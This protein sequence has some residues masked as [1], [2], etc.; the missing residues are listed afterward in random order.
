MS[1]CCEQREQFVLA[2]DRWVRITGFYADRW[3]LGPN[4]Y[5]NPAGTAWR[6]GWQG[7]QGLFVACFPVDGGTGVSEREAW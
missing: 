2:S 3:V 1:N 7:R 5:E 4:S 6:H